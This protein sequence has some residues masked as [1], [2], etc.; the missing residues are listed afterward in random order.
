MGGKV[1]ECE[2]DR[3]IQ[4]AVDLGIELDMKQSIEQ[5]I[6]QI[7]RRSFEIGLEQGIKEGIKEGI[8]LGRAQIIEN[9]LKNKKT[10]AEIAEFCSIEMQEIEN[11][12]KKMLA[13]I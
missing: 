1:V 12:Q 9:M 5:W 8:E 7:N 13:N 6:E 3:I 2:L 4:C 11:V 10:P